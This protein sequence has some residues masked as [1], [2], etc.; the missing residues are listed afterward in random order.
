MLACATATSQSAVSNNQN[1]TGGIFAS[2]QLDV[3]TDASD[4]T[5]TTTATAN[6][7]VASATSGDLAVQ[8]AQA[9]SG[10]VAAA[11]TMNVA[12]GAGSLSSLTAATANSG[13][14]VIVGGGRLSG[15]FL[16]TS[17]SSSI[18]AE[19]QVIGQAAPWNTVAGLQVQAV[20]DAQS[21]GAV[22]ASIV[23]SATQSNASTVSADG[24]VVL[25]NVQQGGAFSALG[26][27]ND[28][29][30][31]G[32]GQSTATLVVGQ[33]NSGQTTQGAIFVSLGDSELT[34]TDAT[35]IGNNLDASNTGGP[36]GLT[37][38]QDNES[39]VHAQSVETSYE[40][41]GAVVTSDGV[42][43]A[44]FAGD[45]G[46]ATT[47]NNTQ[48]NGEGVE[49]TAS[50]ASAGSPGYDVSVSS[51]ATGNAVTG[52]ACSQCGGGVMNATS[53]QTNLGDIQASSQV[54]LA[55][56]ARSVRGVATAVGNT[57]TFY[58]SPT[59]E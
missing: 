38:S 42:G 59:G 56:G 32:Q 19:S 41:G 20:G 29:T 28:L 21:L 23:A 40:F 26:A 2:Q 16:Q 53:N 54:G 44:A 25:Q 5:A 37:D 9:N 43:N 6:S 30:S 18:D 8:S 15:N 48:V 1:N 22:D 4:T 45:I 27:G 11:T 49:S 12:A 58:T 34:Q 13:V 39:F 55:S 17:T 57:A 50:F 31:V 36:L 47:M 33:T 35:A 3:V 14:S 7:T 24:G 10:P 51:T 46:G 52:F